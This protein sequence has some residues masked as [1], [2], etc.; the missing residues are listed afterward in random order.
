MDPSFPVPNA[1]GCALV[2]EIKKK[3]YVYYH[4]TGNKGKCSE[5]WVRE[6]EIACQ[7][8]QAISAIK[9]DNDVFGWVIAALKESHANTKKYHTERMSTL[10]A[11]YEKIQRRLDVMYEDK[12]DGRIDQD[13]YDRKSSVWKKDQDDIL[14]TIERHQT[15]NRAYLD[16]GLKLLEL[17]QRAV[18]L[19]EKQ[20]EKEKRRIINFVCSNST[21]KMAALFQT[22]GNLL[23]CYQKPALLTKKK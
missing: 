9:M 20:P 21:W 3:Q 23:I 13:F 4:C 6:E 18:I 2:A 10:Q 1:S 16:E 12:L 8:S 17:A 14:S 5:K 19:Y 22:T 11:Q 15:A 7:F